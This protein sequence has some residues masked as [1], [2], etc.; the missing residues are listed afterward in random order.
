MKLLRTDSEYLSL[1][2]NRLRSRVLKPD[3]KRDQAQAMI[4][5]EHEETEARKMRK[6]AGP[7]E[8]GLTAESVELDLCRCIACTHRFAT[9]REA[10][11]RNRRTLQRRLMMQRLVGKL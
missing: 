11:F 4:M 5:V 9:D 3:P 10:E 1:G 8:E 7:N 2:T 6:E